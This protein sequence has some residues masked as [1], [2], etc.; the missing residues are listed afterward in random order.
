MNMHENSWLW[1]IMVG[2][3]ADFDSDTSCKCIYFVLGSAMGPKLTE[4]DITES[5]LLPVRLSESSSSIC[6]I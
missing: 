4:C 2:F 3:G 5:M 6:C 1:C